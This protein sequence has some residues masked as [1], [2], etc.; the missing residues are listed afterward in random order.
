MK[1]PGLQFDPKKTYYK[2]LFFFLM[3]VF[4][5][6]FFL[7]LLI[8]GGYSMRGLL[9]AD[10]NGSFMDFFS[11]MILS[12]ENAYA[13]EAV[14]APFALLFYRGLLVLV[15]NILISN[16][17]P[18]LASSS[19]P[20]SIKMYQEFNFPF[21]LYSLLL[22]VLLF[23]ALRGL[24]KGC[25]A[26]KYALIFI[27]FLSAPMLFA[28][29][30]GSDTVLTLALL[31]FF[32]A[33][34]DSE[35]K[36]IANLSLLSLGIACAFSLY[37]LLFCIVLLRKKRFLDTL[38]VFGVC[39]VL[40]VPALFI[41]GGGF[42]GAMQ[43]AKNLINA[44]TGNMLVLSGQLSFPKCAVN[45]FADTRLPNETLVLIG[46]VFALVT[47]IIV[48]TGALLAK[49]EWQQTALICGLIFGLSPLCEANLL[50]LFAIPT[51]LLLDT[52]KT[53]SAV[54]YVSLLFLILT[55]ALI[56]SPDVTSRSYTRMFVTRLTSYGV[57]VFVLLL[58][59][60]SVVDSV[61]GLSKKTV[62][63]DDAQVQ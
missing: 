37:P 48:L 3:T 62:R 19:F 31:L 36:L 10:T 44:W 33:G 52:E 56:V 45:L 13:S 1:I 24:K 60:V 26:E 5:L 58:T 39:L 35:K 18:S 16:Y 59:A 43:L 27:I 57:L 7:V 21:I 2:Q 61:K 34:K 9:A 15:S 12:G 51:V 63:A 28:F 4:A 46:N 32:F 22:L 40:T 29:E 49:K 14:A 8:S 23:F 53:N 50:I 38:K 25:N 11:K 55:Q 30:R 20:A 42:S 41:V 6:S 17:I 54:S 47:G